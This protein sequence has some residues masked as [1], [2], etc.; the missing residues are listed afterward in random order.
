MTK[1]K[2]TTATPNSKSREQLSNELQLIRLSYCDAAP[3]FNTYTGNDPN[4]ITYWTRKRNVLAYPTS[5]A[6]N[7]ST[8]SPAKEPKPVRSTVRGLVDDTRLVKSHI[9]THSAVELCESPTSAGPDF[10]AFAE[11]KF[12]DMK[13]RIVWDLCSETFLEQ[14]FDADAGEVR[15]GDLARGLVKDYTKVIEWA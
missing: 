4:T 2:V 1:A 13:G 15:F 6:D 12:C 3:P 10:V 14:C 9:A 8:R 11:G 5:S 7:L